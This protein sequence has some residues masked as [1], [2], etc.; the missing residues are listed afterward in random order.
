[1]TMLDFVTE[2]P[3]ECVEDDAGD[4]AFVEATRSIGGRDAIEEYMSCGLF[5]LSTSFSL[6]EVED[7]E[8]PVSKI[9]LPIPDF[10]VDRLPDETN[11]RFRVR[12]E[13][14]VKNVVGSY[15]CGEHDACIMV[16]LN[17]GRLSWVFEQADV[18]Y[19]PR[20]EPGSEA[21][22]ET[23][24]KRK[25][26]AGE[27][28][29]SKCEKVSGQ[30][31]TA[32]KPPTT[33]RGTGAASSKA[34]LS[35]IASSKA[36]PSHPKSMPKASATPKTGAPSK[37]DAPAKA[38]VQK[39]VA[40]PSVSKAGVLRISPGLKRPNAEPAQ[41]PKGKH[42]RVDAAPS[43]AFAQVR[44]TIAQPQLPTGSDDDR[45]VTCTM[46]GASPAVLR[47]ASSSSDGS[48]GS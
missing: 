1:M 40:M 42:A 27:G 9:N 6:G 28:P 16:V 34:A 43:P 37:A 33:S 17:E 39:S 41:A 31:S 8:T 35:K 11:D 12:V 4:A 19:G 3:F 2:P 15:A 26:D 32:L 13:L 36:A 14:A 45:V 30:K 48:S 47:S 25:N 23:M 10:L 21:S 24:I 7:K 46:L 38:A 22:K 20:L 44:R 29:M 18:P 5:P